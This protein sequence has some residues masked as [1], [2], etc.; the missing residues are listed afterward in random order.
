MAKTTHTLLSFG[1]VADNRRARY[2]Y[3]ILQTFEAGIILMGSE[4]KSL[5]TGGV[6]IVEAH[7]SEK[8]GQLLLFNVNIPIYKPANRFNHEPKR[9]R[10]LLLKT[11]ELDKIY[12]SIKREGTTLIP[13]SIFFNARGK[14]KVSLGLAKGKKNIDKREDLKN[15]EWQRRKERVLRGQSD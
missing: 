1:T 3:T 14:A 2:D 15:R 6:S 12:G 13:L 4:V 10:V 11:K 7:A 8:D 5:R 9:P